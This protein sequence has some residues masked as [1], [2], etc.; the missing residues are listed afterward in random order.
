MLNRREFLAIAGIGTVLGFQNFTVSATQLGLLDSLVDGVNIDAAALVGLW[1]LTNHPG[2][3]DSSSLLASLSDCRPEASQSDE[4]S[5]RRIDASFVR[6]ASMV[7]YACGDVVFAG[8]WQLAR[9][10]A[11]VCALIALS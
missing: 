3:A 2:E 4:V 5:L 9:T 1:Y 7:D 10:E 11:R 6:R 8:G